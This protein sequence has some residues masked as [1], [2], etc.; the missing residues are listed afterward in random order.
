MKIADLL[1]P[2]QPPQNYPSPAL[3]PLLTAAPMLPILNLQSMDTPM[4]PMHT[5]QKPLKKPLIWTCTL[6]PSTFKRKQELTRHTKSLHAGPDA[7][8][9]TCPN[10]AKSFPRPDALKRHLSS[11]KARLAQ[12]QSIKSRKKQGRRD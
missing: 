7:I 3:T 1:N 8:V 11:L 2:L 9:Y 12:C 10:C 5:L 6:C 4:Q